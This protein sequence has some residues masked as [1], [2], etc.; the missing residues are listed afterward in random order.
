MTQWR[1]QW[2]QLLQSSPSI[3]STL[4]RPFRPE[5][6]RRYLCV[7][8]CSPPTTNISV[9]S[10]RVGLTGY[11]YTVMIT[12]TLH[13]TGTSWVDYTCTAHIYTTSAFNFSG[14]N[15]AQSSVFCIITPSDW[16]CICT[17]SPIILICF[18]RATALSHSIPYQARQAVVMGTSTLILRSSR[19][20]CR[21]GRVHCDWKV[22]SLADRLCALFVGSAC[23]TKQGC[24]IL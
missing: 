18:V 11:N 6:Y 8:F 20:R 2:Q 17:I 3:L 24:L 4:S 22:V 13:T 23:F 19:S 12:Y 10:G 7:T 9:S 21:F 5:T 1:V 16:P 15:S 14:F